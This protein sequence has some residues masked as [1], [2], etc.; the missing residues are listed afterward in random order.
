LPLWRTLV[1]QALERWRL[2]LIWVESVAA[3]SS[4]STLRV[5]LRYRILANGN[6]QNLLS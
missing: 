3:F 6:R 5:D 4:G 1:F 2:G